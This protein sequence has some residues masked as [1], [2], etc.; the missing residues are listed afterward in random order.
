M[1]TRHDESISPVVHF[2][3]GVH[4][5]SVKD[6]EKLYE[7][8]DDGN[9][10]SNEWNEAVTMRL[11]DYKPELIAIDSLTKP[12][13][14]DSLDIDYKKFV[15]R[16]MPDRPSRINGG[17][18]IQVLAGDNT[19][20][21]PNAN[22]T[23][24]YLTRVAF[25]GILLGTGAVTGIQLDRMVHGWRRWQAGYD[26]VTGNFDNE[27]A[28][29]VSR[30]NFLKKTGFAAAAIALAS[31]RIASYSPYEP[32]TEAMEKVYD[33]TAMLRPDRLLSDENYLDGRTALLIQKTYDALEL[34]GMQV[35][36]VV[37]GDSHIHFAQELLSNSDRRA[38]LIRKHT[39]LMVEAAPT[40]E[41][42]YS[43]EDPK[44]FVQERIEGIKKWQ[45]GFGILTISEPDDKKFKQNPEKEI[46]RIVKLDDIYQSKVITEVIKDL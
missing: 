38:Q 13:D 18:S 30:R 2:E 43:K 11:A 4:I 7:K 28:D 36:S 14:S 31:N 12:P 21:S 35:G 37:M 19:W 23:S 32:V 25:H 9:P 1:E 46:D 10:N 29:Q 41:S 42:F 3:P 27:A 17:D 20:N 16:V 40:G 6:V 24:N 22:T 39:E 15:W 34:T 33:Q 8:I 26:H 44:K 5:T 45:V